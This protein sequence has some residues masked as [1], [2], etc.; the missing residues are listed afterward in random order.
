LQDLQQWFFGTPQAIGAGK[1]PM[2]VRGAFYVP[3][4][5]AVNVSIVGLEC[6]R[7]DQIQT[8]KERITTLFAGLCPGA[9]LCL[10][11]FDVVVAQVVGTACTYDVFLEIAEGA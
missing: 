4:I 2:G 10:R 11:Q 9:T 8:I 1:A 6:E 5:A 3:T 7:S